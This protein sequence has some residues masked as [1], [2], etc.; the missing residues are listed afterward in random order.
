MFDKQ[1]YWM[2]EYICELCW[3]TCENRPRAVQ[4]ERSNGKSEAHPFQWL[5]LCE[6]ILFAISSLPIVNIKYSFK[7]VR[8]IVLL[9]SEESQTN[10]TE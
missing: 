6:C 10:Q 5:S 4:T 2:T 7:R 9:H 3:Q 1:Q 8:V